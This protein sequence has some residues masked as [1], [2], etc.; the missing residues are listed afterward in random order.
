MLVLLFWFMTFNKTLFNLYS[1]CTAKMPVVY[2]KIGVLR[3]WLIAIFAQKT[4]LTQLSYGNEGPT[5]IIQ[6]H[7]KHNFHVKIS[8]LNTCNFW[9]KKY[10]LQKRPFSFQNSGTNSPWLNKSHP[11]SIDWLP[12]LLM[13]FCNF[14][15]LT[16]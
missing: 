13:Q 1:I 2:K 5:V 3:L 10:K 4:T 8:M 14:R 12:I 6:L 16:A 11:F 7:A 15:T 9:H